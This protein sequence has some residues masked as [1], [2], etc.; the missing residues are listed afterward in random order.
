[1]NNGYLQEM[2]PRQAIVNLGAKPEEIKKLINSQAYIDAVLNGS[3][4]EFLR[5]T[6]LKNFKDAKGNFNAFLVP[7]HY[8]K[9]GYLPMLT[10]VSEGYY[11]ALLENPD[12]SPSLREDLIALDKLG[13]FKGITNPFNDPNFSGFVKEGSN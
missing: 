8:G 6:V 12:I 1:M 5:K 4:D 10:T 13:V 2:G 3:E 9:N 11:K 7:I